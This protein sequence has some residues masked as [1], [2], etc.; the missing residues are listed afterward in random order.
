MDCAFIKYVSK[1]L[2]W[3]NKNILL[4]VL[5]ILCTASSPLFAETL[6][7]AW[8]V[9]LSANHRIQ[10]SRKSTLSSHYSLEAARSARIPSLTLESGYTVLNQEP[11]TFID[12]PASLFKKVPMG[13]DKSLSYKATVSIPVF[14]GGRI[15]EGIFAADSGL[16][17]SKQDEAKTILDIKMSVAEAYVTILRAKHAFEVAESNVSSLA[18]HTRDVSEFY[19]QGMITKN[20]L[21]ASQVALAD[22]RQRSIQAL[23]NLDIA[24]ASYNRLLGRP[25]DQHV[26][27][28][29][30]HPAHTA[31]DV[32]ELTSRAIGKR[33]ELL[34]LSEQSKSLQHQASGL[35]AILWPQLAVS[36]GYNYTQNKYLVY[37][38]VWS[39]T[40]G[41]KWD[42][43]DGGIARNN[44]RALLQKAESLKTLRDDAA[45]VIALQVRQ[46][47]LDI[48]ETAK[49]IPVTH[50]AVAQ[51]E[52]N[53][54]VTKDRY[55]EGI[56]TNTEVLDAETL[57]TKSYSN[58]YNALYDAVIAQ[59]RMKYAIAEL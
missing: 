15:S 6:E 50:D 32:N 17:V 54:R 39:A 58:Y 14:T 31:L 21:L 10:A 3:L 53:L 44:A 47:Y 18:A 33:P 11:E 27:I 16:Q 1:V 24:Y 12:N 9:A 20:D 40:V 25:L 7:D 36:G 52:E 48:E 34:S 4:A 49:R 37:E 45:S 56:G 19:E 42:L 46:A 28:D 26:A 51:S 55:R 29:D 8:Q 22:A 5:F 35:T 59:I 43:F 23:Y 41:L 38:D 2:Y 13:E 57:R 30:L